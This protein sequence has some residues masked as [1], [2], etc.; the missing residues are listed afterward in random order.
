MT[1]PLTMS[2]INQIV[3]ELYIEL[4][5]TQERVLEL[6]RALKAKL[7]ANPNPETG[8]SVPSGEDAAE[9]FRSQGECDARGD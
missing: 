7:D 4:H 1:M 2:K 6:E 9:G 3:G 5:F 8:G